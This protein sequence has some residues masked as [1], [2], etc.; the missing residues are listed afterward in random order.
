MN[1]DFVKVAG[2]LTPT[3]YQNLKRAL[4]LGKWP[5]G[6]E[7]LPEQKIIC[8]QAVIAYEQLNLPENKR[9][10]YMAQSCASKSAE[11]EHKSL[12]DPF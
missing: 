1:D 3:V 11:S 10:G 12:K 7:L 9:T 4:E 8:M 5:D 6:R 2:D